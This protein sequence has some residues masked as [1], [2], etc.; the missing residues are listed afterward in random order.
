MYKHIKSDVEGLKDVLG[1]MGVRESCEHVVDVVRLR[2]REDGANIR[3]MILEF[4]SEY[5]TWALGSNEDEI[6][7]ERK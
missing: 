3:P 1:K 6:N 5:D 2:Q 7:A 4:R